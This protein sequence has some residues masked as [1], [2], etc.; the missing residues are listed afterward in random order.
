[1]G[2]ADSNP[3][4]RPMRQEP[5]RALVKD[6]ETRLPDSG[7]I[8]ARTGPARLADQNP[9]K[10]PDA[11]CEIESGAVGFDGVACLC[12][13]RAKQREVEDTAAL[14]KQLDWWEVPA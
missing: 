11:E 2:L 1:M 5:R 4:N 8:R 12:D 6:D 14:T 9:S 13:E 3:D 7:S 10:R